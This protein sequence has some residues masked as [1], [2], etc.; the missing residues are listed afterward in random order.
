MTFNA[1]ALENE[2]LQ[3]DHFFEAHPHSPL[4]PEQKSKF[5]GLD[6][7]PPNEQL[8][9][10]I[11]PEE[12][13][14]KEEI[15]IQTSTGDVRHYQRWG[16][17]KFSVGEATAE[18]ILFYNPDQDH[19]FLPFKDDTSRAETYGSG[20]Y[21]DPQR[22][23]DGRFLIDFNHAYSPYCAY[24]TN[25]SCP[26]TPAENI[27]NVRIEAGEKKPADTWAMSY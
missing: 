7:F 4:T 14:N 20:R 26:L 2:R 24:N 8:Y 5:D 3:K 1:L 17:V 27:L 15:E 9:L 23:A 16:K 12:F 19:F 11:E 25:W 18:L 22:L 6:Y 10:L 21:L 13:A